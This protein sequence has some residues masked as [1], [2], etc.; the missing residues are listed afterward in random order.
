MSASP[1]QQHC[2]RGEAIGACAQFNIGNE[3]LG[4]YANL[5]A[6]FRA[7]P[8]RITPNEL[9]LLSEIGMHNNHC[10]IDSGC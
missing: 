1:W 6:T 2:W 3:T 4:N 8:N 7:S 9:A 10:F 5:T